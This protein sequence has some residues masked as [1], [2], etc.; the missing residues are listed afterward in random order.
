MAFE[1]R[2][3]SVET[4]ITTERLFSVILVIET[5][6]PAISIAFLLITPTTTDDDGCETRR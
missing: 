5:S 6:A 3:R 1:W 2:F 4:T